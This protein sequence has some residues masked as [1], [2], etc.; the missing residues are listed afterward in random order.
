MFRAKKGGL[1]SLNHSLQ[2]L[3]M[4]MSNSTV[5]FL[6]PRYAD[7]RTKDLLIK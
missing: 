1:Q 7:S 3:D 2:G 4:E 6:V 5:R